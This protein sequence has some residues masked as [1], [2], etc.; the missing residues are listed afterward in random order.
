MTIGFS[1]HYLSYQ[2]RKGNDFKFK[3]GFYHRILTT[4]TVFIVYFAPA[5]L[6][7]EKNKESQYGKCISDKDPLMNISLSSF[8]SF[9]LGQHNRILIQ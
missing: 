5:R 1:I 4:L 6:S 7:I 3:C 9:E 8:H 2:K